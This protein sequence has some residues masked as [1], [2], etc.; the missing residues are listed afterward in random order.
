MD[1]QA[2]DSIVRSLATGRSRRS[3]LR[4]IIGGAGAFAVGYVHEQ[5]VLSDR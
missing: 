1:G 3:V 4:G 5:L 2:F